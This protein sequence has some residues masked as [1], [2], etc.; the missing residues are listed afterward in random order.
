MTNDFS[1]IVEHDVVFQYNM[2]STIWEGRKGIWLN[3]TTVHLSDTIKQ[4]T[5][6]LATETV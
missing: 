5:G 6:R 3:I 2:E 4:I 1:A